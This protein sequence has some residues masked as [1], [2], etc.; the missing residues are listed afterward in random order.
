[1]YLFSKRFLKNMRKRMQELGATIY[2]HTKMTDI[3]IENGTITSI[4]ANGKQL[5]FPFLA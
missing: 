1:M 4:T 3:Q 2:F 5:F